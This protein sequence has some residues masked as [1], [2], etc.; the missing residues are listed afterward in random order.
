MLEIVPPALRDVRIRSELVAANG[1]QFEVD[2]CGSGQRLA[3]CLH[4]F[5]EHS[6]SWRFQLPMLADLGFK[7]WAPNL[8]SLIH[9]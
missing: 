5:P 4:G 2:V 6:F 9:I 7:A 8:L 3:L 1:L